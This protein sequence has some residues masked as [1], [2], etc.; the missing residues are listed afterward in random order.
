M[1]KN[2]DPVWFYKHLEDGDEA[3]ETF[4]GRKA[5]WRLRVLRNIATAGV[6]SAKS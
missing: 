5:K 6:K 4:G 2:T 3:A 1:Q